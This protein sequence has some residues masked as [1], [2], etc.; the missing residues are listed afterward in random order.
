[1]LGWKRGEKPYD[2][3]YYGKDGKFRKRTPEI[4][5]QD[6]GF[7]PQTNDADALMAL[8]E[9]FRHDKIDRRGNLGFKIVWHCELQWRVIPG[10]DTFRAV[11]G[12]GNLCTAICTALW[13]WGEEKCD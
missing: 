11:F 12:H 1:L 9:W 4:I 5:P 13:K 7:R 8:M 2:T 10:E 3:H 6:G